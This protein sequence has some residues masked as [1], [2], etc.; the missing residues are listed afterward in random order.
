APALLWGDARFENMVFSDDL[1]P[2]AVLDWDMT[3]VGAPEH[4]LAWFTSLDLTIHQLFGTRIDGFPSRAE[5]IA[6]FEEGEGRPAQ[7]L[8]WYETLAMVR[9]TAIMTRISHLQLEAGEP[10]LL[11]I[12]DNPL[13]DLL[14]DRIG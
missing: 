2:V 10:L 12:H 6:R 1:R 8:E 4:D 9:S 14:R 13:L 11:P 3:T 5:T 7:D